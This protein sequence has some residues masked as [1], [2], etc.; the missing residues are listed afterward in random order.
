VVDGVFGERK[1][2]R[3]AIDLIPALAGEDE[4]KSANL[5]FGLQMRLGGM[6]AQ[7]EGYRSQAGLQCFESAR[8]LASTLGES[9]R[10]SFA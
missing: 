10:R 7:F 8:R 9:D 1:H 2:Y 4:P 6:L 5:E 3:S